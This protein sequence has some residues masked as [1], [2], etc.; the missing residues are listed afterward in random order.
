M[1][2]AGWPKET[3]LWLQQEL[4]KHSTSR[5]L[6][7]HCFYNRYTPFYKLQDTGLSIL[8]EMQQ[9]MTWIIYSEFLEEWKQDNISQNTSFCYFV[10]CCT[11]LIG[12]YREPELAGM[13]WFNMHKHVVHMC[14][15][16]YIE[17]KKKVFSGWI[18][19]YNY[20]SFCIIRVFTEKVRCE[21]SVLDR[22]ICHV[23]QFLL[24]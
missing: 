1:C 18:R 20:E 14:Y 11:V 24:H 19:K 7:V 12:H 6:T 4:W 3:K 8:S 9:S 22:E 16:F 5:E 10:D 21:R 17:N 15:K 2:S 13:L 23:Q